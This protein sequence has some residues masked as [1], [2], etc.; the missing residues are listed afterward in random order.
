[1]RGFSAKEIAFQRDQNSNKAKPISDKK[2]AA[3]QLRRREDHHPVI[4]PTPVTKEFKVGDNVFLK[5]GKS[6]LRGREMFKILDLFNYQNEKWAT[7]LKT[8]TQFRA[9]PY[10]VK[11][12]EIFLV[13]LSISLPIPNL[14]WFVRSFSS[15]VL[16]PAS[17][18]CRKGTTIRDVV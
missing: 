16:Q 8:E 5:N 3:E 15:D 17:N 7:L 12:S 18:S 14:V 4:A 11:L 6:K 10:K 2:M 1:M 9:K 13:V